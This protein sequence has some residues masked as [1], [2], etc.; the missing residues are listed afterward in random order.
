MDTP[1]PLAADWLVG[2]GEMG[3]RIRAHDWSR[4][5]LGPIEAWPQS[6]RSALS[7][8]LGSRFPIVLYWGTERIVL[9][10]DA[11]AEILGKKHPWA[12]GRACREVW[13]E[14][15]DVI[16]PMLDGVVASGEATWSDDQLLLLERRGYPEECYFSFSFSPVGGASRQ[17][18]GVFTAVIETT[19]RVLGERRLR[20]LRDLAARAALARARTTRGAPLLQRPRTIPPTFRLR[21]C[22]GPTR[23]GR[24]PTLP[25]PMASSVR[26]RQSTCRAS[27]LKARR[28]CR[29]RDRAQPLTGSS[30][31]GSAR[32]ARS[33][34]STAA[35][36]TLVAGQIAT[37]IANA[38][39][40]E[41]ERRRAE[42][43]AE[44]DRAKT[45]FF[46][47]VSHE[48]RT[49]LTLMLGP[50]EDLLAD[51]RRCRAPSARAARA[52]RTAT[53]CGCSSWS[54]RCS[55]SRASR[56]AACRRRYE[57][58]DLAALTAE[59]ASIFRSACE[60]R[61]ARASRS[62][63]RRSREPVYVDREMWEKIVLN[64]LSNAFKFTLEGEIDGRRAATRG[65]ARRAR[66]A[67]HRH[68]HPGRGAAALFERFHRVEG[69][70]GAHPR[71]HAASASRWCRSWC[72][73]HGGAIARRERARARAPRSRSRMPLGSAH[74]PAERVAAPRRRVADRRARRRLSSTR[75]CAGCPT[76]TPRRPPTP[77]PHERAARAS[78]PTTTPTCA[79]TCARLLGRALRRRGGRR[80]RARRSRR[81]ARAARPRPHRRDDAAARRLRAARASCAPTRARATCR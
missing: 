12:L 28:C 35:S 76:A 30:S 9:Y 81:R 39:A 67:R 27:A 54:T 3:A 53:A 29:S 71:G 22:T 33:T 58:T 79:T 69:A 24:S 65:G 18:E 26:R 49:P 32:G 41:E 78:S 47:N 46:T 36:S 73:L 51:G 62:T 15:W 48:F 42:A 70:R 1:R 72:K 64:L 50:L 52:S 57:P 66:G 68:R 44:L 21:C 61:R 19:R 2:G 31:P 6:L 74:L 55:T 56:P 11:Y 80:R 8:C 16:A 63:A 23:K 14:I 59:L 4:T 75:R 38:R 40:Y 17:A 10:N 77:R 60:Q 34:T 43:L 20:A 37:A 5:P 25:Q 45:A 13:S 7:I